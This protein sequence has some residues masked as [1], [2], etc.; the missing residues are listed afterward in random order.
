GPIRFGMGGTLRVPRRAT[1]VARGLRQ[2]PAIGETLSRSPEPR[3]WSA[4]FSKAPCTPTS[5]GHVSRVVMRSCPLR[6]RVIVQ[7]HCAI[8]TRPEGALASSILAGHKVEVPAA[9]GGAMWILL[10]GGQN[11]AP[12]RRFR[13]EEG[14]L[15]VLA[16]REQILEAP[17]VEVEA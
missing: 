6:T 7:P 1:R 2:T 13:L 3:Q 4:G 10:G 12:V 8:A 9:H 15:R 5:M 11:A 14:I 17:P 16:C